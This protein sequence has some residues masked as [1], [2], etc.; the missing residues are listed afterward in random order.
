M[1]LIKYL[2]ALIFISFISMQMNAQCTHDEDHDCIDEQSS[3]CS[4]DLPKCKW[5]SNE[6]Y[7]SIEFRH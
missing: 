7:R 1:K 5:Y 3:C 2:S 4:S 6:K